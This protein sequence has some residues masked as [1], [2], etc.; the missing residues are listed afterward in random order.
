MSLPR[1][2]FSCPACGHPHVDRGEWATKPHH[3]HLCEKCGNV[4]DMGRISVGVWVGV[5]AEK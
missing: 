4:W 5:G 1:E 2:V 3:K